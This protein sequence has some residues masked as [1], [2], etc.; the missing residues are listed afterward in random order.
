[1][2][3]RR[4]LAAA[5]A[6]ALLGAACSQPP[7]HLKYVSKMQ[8]QPSTSAT[9]AD[10]V[11]EAI[12]RSV[13]EMVLPGG[14]VEMTTTVGEY[15][16]RLEWD[17]ALPGI[18]AGAAMVYNA[19]DG[20]S[21]VI[22]AEARTFWRVPASAMAD[23]IPAEAKPQVTSAKTGEKETVAGVPAE[24]MTFEIRMP[25]PAP[26]NQPRP[27]GMPAEV[28]MSGEAWVA[29]QYG[30]YLG[31]ASK[32]PAMNAL[33]MDALAQHGLQMRQILRSPVFGNRQLET[34]VTSLSEERVPQHRFQVPA[35]FTETP[36]V[37]AVGSR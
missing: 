35:G 12:G 14:S 22:N 10:P 28:T 5:A 4:V 33:G 13:G 30:H 8:M 37:G 15:G 6:W 19:A 36:P 21:V 23:L 29:P 11:L 3:T 32:L 26:P 18:P 34:V 9:P 25:L 2:V 17:R 20:A 16:I 24:R 1:M 7:L 31:A 27:P